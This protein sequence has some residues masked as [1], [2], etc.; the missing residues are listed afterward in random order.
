L[1][2]REVLAY[3]CAIISLACGAGLLLQRTAAAASRVLLGSLLL[4]MLFF[5]VP[6]IFQAPTATVSWWSC[7]ETAAMIAGAWVVYVWFASDRDAQRLRFATGDSGLRIARV[8]FGLGL[9]PFGIAHFTYLDRTVSMVPGWLPWHLGWAYFTG[10]SMIA[11]GVAVV[12]GVYAR[13]AAALATLEFALFTLLVW[14]PV[15]AA[16]HPTATDWTEFISSCALT[17]TAWV[18]TDSYRGVPW[19]AFMRPMLPQRAT[20]G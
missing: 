5:R 20:N 7:G 16:G 12:F 14:I 13:L 3:A 4:W 10:A 11:A 8:L 15:V 2:A 18:V 9:V 1:P 17:A 6:L 19:L